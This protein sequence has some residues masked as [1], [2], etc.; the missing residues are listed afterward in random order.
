[1]THGVPLYKAALRG[2][3]GTAKT[4]LEQDPSLLTACIS[5]GGQTVLHFA[6]GTKYVHFVEALVGM[7][8]DE[9]LELRDDKENTAFCSA[10]ATGAVQVAQIMLRRN[11]NLATIRGGEKMTPLYMAAMFG[12]SEMALCLYSK[13]VESLEEGDRIGIFFTS[14]NTGLYG[15]YNHITQQNS[16]LPFSFSFDFFV[17]ASNFFTWIK[18]YIISVS[19]D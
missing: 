1:M 6:A 9:D 15:K 3:W 10:V 16:H 17:L 8:R 5:K 2:D 12:R 7:M 18:Y 19:L 14:I 4:I 11:K 13:S